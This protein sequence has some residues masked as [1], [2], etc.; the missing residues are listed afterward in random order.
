MRAAV[1]IIFVRASDLFADTS[2][3][4]T[5]PLHGLIAFF[6]KILARQWPNKIDRTC[7]YGESGTKFAKIFRTGPRTSRVQFPPPP[8]FIG[9]IVKKQRPK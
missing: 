8:L 9:K 6:T 2:S 3:Q 1:N 5:T 7:F 4:S